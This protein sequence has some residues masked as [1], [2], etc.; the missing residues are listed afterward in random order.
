MKLI[1]LSVDGILNSDEWNSK[2]QIEI[3]NKQPI[4]E[5]AVK[6][7]S[8]LIKNTKAKIVIYSKYKE[9]FNEAK[10]P[11]K[12]EGLVLSELFNKYGLKIFNFIPGKENEEDECL[13]FIDEIKDVDKWIVLSNGF[14]KKFEEH[15]V[16]IDKTTGLKTKDVIKIQNMLI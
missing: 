14:V 7:L 5:D 11:I 9:Y 6:L 3:E 16:V 8:I 4:D 15:Q 10:L 2:H 13:A 12:K 1:F